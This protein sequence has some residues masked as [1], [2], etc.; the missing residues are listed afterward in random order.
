MVF[1]SQNYNYPSYLDSLKSDISSSDTNTCNI[2]LSYVLYR[3]QASAAATN[4]AT[5]TAAAA[6]VCMAESQFCECAD[7]LSGPHAP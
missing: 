1:Q 3:A 4:T 7:V 2:P 6:S 5:A